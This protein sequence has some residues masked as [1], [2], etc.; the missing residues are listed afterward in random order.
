MFCGQ[1]LQRGESPPRVG[2]RDG[3]PGCRAEWQVWGYASLHV[4]T[5][6]NLRCCAA[7]VGLTRH[8]HE[9]T[10]KRSG[11]AGRERVE[12]EEFSGAAF[13]GVNAISFSKRACP[14]ARIPRKHLAGTRFMVRWRKSAT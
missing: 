2:M 6:K 14:L 5:S 4:I 9:G 8:P 11:V 1:G 13:T 3:V 7:G 10:V 12:I